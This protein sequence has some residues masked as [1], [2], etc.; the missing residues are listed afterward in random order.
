LSTA[1]KRSN[2]KVMSFK[3][4]EKTHHAR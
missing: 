3:R 1:G 4:K 2:G